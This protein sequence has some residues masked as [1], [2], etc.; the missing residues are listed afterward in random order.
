MK[1]SKYDY[2]VTFYPEINGVWKSFKYT[3]S[4]SIIYYWIK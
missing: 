3:T 1:N 4:E 2:L